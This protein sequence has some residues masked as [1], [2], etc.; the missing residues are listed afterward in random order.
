MICTQSLELLGIGQ[1]ANGQNASAAGDGA[2]TVYA[3]LQPN[4]GELWI[5]QLA[6]MMHD[7][8][9]A[10][11]IMAWYWYDG[12]TRTALFSTVDA[13]AQA[14]YVPLCGTRQFAAANISGL[15][16][17]GSPIVCDHNNYLQAGCVAPAAPHKAYL[18]YVVRKIRLAEVRGS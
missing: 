6:V 15:S 17:C 7:D 10:S 3:S 4:E 8:D 2:A 12:S 14:T 1:I 16:S 13:I 5:V 18:N 11:R 9:A